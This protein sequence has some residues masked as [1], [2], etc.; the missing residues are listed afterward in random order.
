MISGAGGFENGDVEPEP[1]PEPSGLTLYA[2]QLVDISHTL[3]GGSVRLRDWISDSGESRIVVR[4]KEI[5]A[6]L[7]GR[8]FESY[9]A[10]SSDD[11]HEL[12]YRAIK[13]MHDIDPSVHWDDMNVMLNYV[14]LVFARYTMIKGQREHHGNTMSFE[15]D[16]LY[17]ARDRHVL[18][19]GLATIFYYIDYPNELKTV[20]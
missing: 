5:R 8:A 7:G 3:Q 2:E 10:F 11:R 12:E 13:A 17:E 6:S 1:E 15:S 16:D 4:P 9:L 19:G 20:E 14:P 18:I